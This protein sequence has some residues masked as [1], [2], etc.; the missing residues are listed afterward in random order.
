MKCSVTKMASL[1]DHIA[2]LSSSRDVIQSSYDKQSLEVEKLHSTLESKEEMI[3]QLQEELAA[4]SSA[5]EAEQNHAEMQALQEQLSAAKKAKTELAVRVLER[6][7]EVKALKAELAAAKKPEG[8]KDDEEM[9]KECEN[10][11]RE[12]EE[13]KKEC[14]SVKKECEE[15][16]KECEEMK[17]EKEEMKKECEEVKREKDEMQKE[18]E[19]ASQKLAAKKKLYD[20]LAAAEIQTLKKAVEEVTK[21]RDAL[22]QSNSELTLERTRLQHELEKSKEQARESPEEA[23][24]SEVA[25]ARGR[26]A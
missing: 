18:K 5:V 9:K 2:E 4:K 14:E 10:A 21:E 13:I 7:K 26:E 25:T 11:K 15:M 17:R 23:A 1:Q 20:S 3:H 6:E 24:L 16:K 12:K 19:E 8:E 22:D